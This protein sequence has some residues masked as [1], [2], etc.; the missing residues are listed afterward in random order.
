MSLVRAKFRCR[1]GVRQEHIQLVQYKNHYAYGMNPLF[2]KTNVCGVC[3]YMCACVCIYIYM[4]IYIYI[5][6]CVC[7]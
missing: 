4:Y 6:V 5:Y 7:A 2:T 1:V 3:V